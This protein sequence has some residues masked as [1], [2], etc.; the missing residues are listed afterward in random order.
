M[1]QEP[2]WCCVAWKGASGGCFRWLAFRRAGVRHEELVSFGCVVVD[3]NDFLVF[4]VVL[5][6][7]ASV[8]VIM[9]FV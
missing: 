8:P 9:R 7:L 2:F 1:D 6:K 4:W 3:L 5:F